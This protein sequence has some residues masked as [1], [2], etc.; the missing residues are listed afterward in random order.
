MLTHA[1]CRRRCTAARRTCRSPTPPLLD[2]A[3]H[4]S[5]TLPLAGVATSDCGAVAAVAD[6]RVAIA[7]L[8]VVVVGVRSPMRA[9]SRGWP[10]GAGTVVG[11]VVAWSGA[12]QPVPSAP[13]ASSARSAP[14]RVVGSVGAGGVVGSVGVGVRS[15]CRQ[16]QG[17]AEPPRKAG[18]AALRWSADQPGRRC[19]LGRRRPHRLPWQPSWRGRRPRRRDEYDS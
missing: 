8:G 11:R 6:V 3:S 7:E 10:D 1:D 18:R 12:R 17:Q 15:P 19:R 16:L 14:G 5:W 13:E 4:F 2:G 9:S